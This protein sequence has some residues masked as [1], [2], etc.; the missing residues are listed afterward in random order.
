MKSAARARRR[1]CLTSGAALAV[2]A[3]VAPAAMAGT[4]SGNL[5][6][7][8]EITVGVTSPVDGDSFIVPA[9]DTT[10]D[11]PLSGT[12]SIATGAPNTSWIYVV[13]ISGS[14]VN[15]MCDSTRTILACEQVAVKGLND[16]VVTDGSALESAVVAFGTSA[17]PADMDPA[18]GE[19]RFTPPSG[20]NVDTVIDSL[21]PGTIG[22]FT[23]KNVGTSTN[24]A[25]ALAAADT[26]VQAATGTQVNVVFLS[27]GISE[28][29][30]LAA[31]N[32]AL[33]SVAAGATIYPF[34][35]GAAASCTVGTLGNLQAMA[36][37]SGTTCEHVTNPANLPDVIKNVTA[38]SLTGLTVT[39]DGNP[40][41]ATTS[42]ALPT[43]GPADITWTAPGNDLAPGTH[44][45]CA[46][47]SGLGPASDDTAT[48]SVTR[49]ES[50]SVF[51][52]AL[53]PPTATNEL[54][55]DDTHTV[56]A[57]VTG[58][59]SD[60]GGHKVDFSISAGPNAGDSGTCAPASCETNASG[61]VTFTYTVPVEPDSLGTDTI[62]AVGHI[63]GHD[64][65]RTASKLWQDTTPPV[66]QCV[67]STNPGGNEPQA[68]G[69]GG[70]GQN[71]D[72]F[73]RLVATDDV[74]PA[75]DLDL[76]VKDDGSSTTWG[77]FAVD[78]DIKYVE[79][80]GA[81]PSQKPGSGAV[82][83]NLKGKGDAEVYAIDGSG[84]RSASVKCLVPNAPQ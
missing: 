59:A 68:P 57:T 54:G 48:G 66:A 6:N 16:L 49:C 74:W 62:T 28:A 32:T 4:Q 2:A 34:A 63:D 52:F 51:G 80:N 20:S 45:V 78:T 64:A 55:S 27:D 9:G 36:T 31:F 58:P 44:E 42:T 56:T 65:T 24:F 21:T 69:N 73:Y 19:Q 67:P 18:A 81:N 72:G 7:G 77:P 17:E 75:S 70:Q 10:V 37:A 79:A 25:A 26:A 43:A 12:A 5:P 22:Q 29:G 76:F 1:A 15:L 3:L 47:A 8:A 38:T 84:N 23:A 83:W 33:N 82:E 40:V 13:D 41:A 35:V 50:F 30:S 11:V 39:L 61:V 46:T 53:T 60:L 14:T 71:Q